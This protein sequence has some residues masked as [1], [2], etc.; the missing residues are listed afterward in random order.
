VSTTSDSEML[1]PLEPQVSWA[2]LRDKLRDEVGWIFRGQSRS[3]WRL[4]SANERTFPAERR[5]KAKETLVHR[6]K[7]AMAKYLPSEQLPQGHLD[8]LGSMQHH[9]AP[10]RL[11]DFTKS[12]YV[13]A[14]FAVEDVK[15][16]EKCVV[17]A[18]NELGCRSKA[19]GR[20]EGPVWDWLYRS[21]D[22][23]THDV[24]APAGLLRTNQRQVAQQ[25]IFLVQGSVSRSLEHCGRET[26]GAQIGEFI[27][28]YQID[29]N[30]RGEI[31]HDLRTFTHNQKHR[32]YR[33][34]DRR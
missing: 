20:I 13:A 24:V 34:H 18:V 7:Q 10:T 27:R 3:V 5:A 30:C 4:Q 15:P 2:K 12:P 9:G 8:L 22:W 32:A 29:G 21:D 23:E 33:L 1:V 31:L 17:W 26:F 6:Y 16:E 11:L 28:C 25:S 14:Y 19:E